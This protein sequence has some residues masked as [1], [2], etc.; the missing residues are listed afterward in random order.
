MLGKRIHIFWTNHRRKFIVGSLLLLALTWVYYGVYTQYAPIEETILFVVLFISASIELVAD[1]V[2]DIKQELETPVDIHQTS[3][4]TL[5]PLKRVI[6]S[7]SPTTVY[8]L[9]YNSTSVEELLDAAI[10]YNCDTRLLIKDP[11]QAR[12][13]AQQSNIRSQITTHYEKH[14]NYD[15]LK[16]HF[17]SKPSSIKARMV[18]DT[19]LCTGWYT[20]DDR[21]IDREKQ[22][23]GKDNPMVCISKD[24]DS[25]KYGEIS[26]WFKDVYFDLWSSGI[27]FE[28]L[29][30]AED[31]DD[32][33]NEAAINE[34][35]VKRVSGNTNI[36]KQQLFRESN[37]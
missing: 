17:Y 34:E 22:V 24:M 20:F 33:R 21:G 9:E 18:D 29:Y 12:N 14:Y 19:L 13:D 4:S 5:E 11:R 10:E 26:S 7:E 2:L 30:H 15:G 31:Y 16:I 28:E 23:W 36:E 32:L 1:E 27:S 3:V 35:W 6:Q 8:L 25:S 37:R